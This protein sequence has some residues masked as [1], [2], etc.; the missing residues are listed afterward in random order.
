MTF[1]RCIYLALKGYLRINSVIPS[2]ACLQLKNYIFMKTS[3]KPL[4]AEKSSKKSMKPQFFSILHASPS[5]LDG[6]TSHYR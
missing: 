5:L 6:H 4:F 2:S 3:P 1:D